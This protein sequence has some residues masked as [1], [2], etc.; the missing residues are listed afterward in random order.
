MD[1]ESGF[2]SDSVSNYSGTINWGKETNSYVNFLTSD[3]VN[4]YGEKELEETNFKYIG[5]STSAEHIASL[6]LSRFDHPHWILNINVPFWEN[7][8]LELMN[9]VEYLSPRMPSYF[10]TSA[11]A[12]L[13]THDG[14]EVDV[15]KG[16]Y[17]KRAQRYTCQIIGREIVFDSNGFPSINFDLRV[18]KPYHANDPTVVR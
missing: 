12:K 10:G 18:I 1:L 16:H 7:R 11:R 4:L 3:S 2:N 5:D 6:I 9:V 8:S 14:A 15:I 13:P 17:W